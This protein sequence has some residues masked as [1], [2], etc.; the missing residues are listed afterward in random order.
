MVHKIGDINHNFFY[1]SLEI[2]ADVVIA[3]T[4]SYI[5]VKSKHLIINGNIGKRA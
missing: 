2:L 5:I 4:I 1:T 3:L